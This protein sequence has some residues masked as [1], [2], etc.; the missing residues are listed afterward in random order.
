MRLS[1]ELAQRIARECYADV[2]S[3]CRRHAPAGHEASDLAQETFLRFVRRG[4][5]RE[6]GKPLAYLL[7]I[8][9][10]VCIDASRRAGLE[11][12]RLSFDVADE[13]PAAGDPGLADAIA[14]L[15]SELAEAVEL[16]YGS[17]LAVGEVAQALGISRFAARR[18]LKRALKL[19]KEEI[20]GGEET[21]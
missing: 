8:A 18:R 20:E 13:L 6:Q 3:Y 2:L 11:T 1:E 16:R 15:P 7:A 5:Y 4:S 9:R 14:G 10:S 17:D 21:R 19:L 12:V